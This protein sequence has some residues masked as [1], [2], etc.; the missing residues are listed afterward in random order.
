MTSKKLLLAGLIAALGLAGTSQAATVNITPRIAGVLNADFTPA[1]PTLIVSNDG[2]SLV[3]NP[4]D[5]KLLL[6]VQIQMTVADGIFG[7]SAF[8]LALDNLEQS[9]DVPGWS[10]DTST[11]DK[12]G[13][14]PGGV[15]AKWADNGDFGASGSDLQAI[16]VGLAPKDFGTAA[17]P[18]PRLGQNGEAAYM[19]EVYLE[20]DP[21][22]AGESGGLSVVGVQASQV[23]GGDLSA[24]G[25]EGIGGSIH[26][27]VVPEPSTLALLGLGSALLAFARKRR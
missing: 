2:S 19:G 9:V 1:D 11:V 22:A 3:L 21:V 14:L 4:H 13:N 18:R 24:D 5:S 10:P 8:N 7:N 20:I 23:L 25:V 16:I 26:F 17:D 27:Q 12:N 6:Q 15:V